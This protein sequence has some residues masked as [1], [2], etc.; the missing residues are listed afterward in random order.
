MSLES[1]MGAA[2]F[3]DV[4][5]AWDQS[6]VDTSESVNSYEAVNP[7]RLLLVL[8]GGLVVGAVMLAVAGGLAANGAGYGLTVLAIVVVGIYKRVDKDRSVQPTYAPRPH[9][10]WA[11]GSATVAAL[12]VAAWLAWLLATGL[13][14]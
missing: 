7:P 13:A 5:S 2:P 4:P 8:A 11:V 3:G 12:V 6:G 9:L 10:R 1:R 14:S